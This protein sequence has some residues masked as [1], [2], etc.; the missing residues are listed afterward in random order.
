LKVFGANLIVPPD[1]LSLSSSILITNWIVHDFSINTSLN[2][3]LTSPEALG[4]HAF[5]SNS[6]PLTTIFISSTAL[7]LLTQ[8]AT[9]EISSNSTVPP[10]SVILPSQITISSDPAAASIVHNFTLERVI[11]PP[12]N[13][14]TAPATGV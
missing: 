8:E 13:V 2:V 12:L 1:K 3:N 5:H 9:I 4:V 7:L 11:F 6:S 10:Q 14:Y